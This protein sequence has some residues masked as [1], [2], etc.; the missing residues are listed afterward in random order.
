MIISSIEKKLL[1]LIYLN[2]QIISWKNNNLNTKI[3]SIFDIVM[4]NIKFKSA[5]G[6]EDKQVEI[7]SPNGAGGGYNLMIDKYLHGRLFKRN[8]IWVA[9]FHK[10]NEYTGA[11]IEVLGEIIDK[12][13][14]WITIRKI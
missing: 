5:F 9:F 14:D 8:N 13:N 7:S 3:I 4:E 1:F 10:D 12:R 2:Y 6:D 11:D